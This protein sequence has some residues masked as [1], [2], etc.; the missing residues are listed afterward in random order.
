MQES[1]KPLVFLSYAVEDSVWVDAFRYL[2]RVLQLRPWMAPLDIAPGQEWDVMI[3]RAIQRADF[4]VA[5][6]SRTSIEKRGYV[7]REYRLALRTCNELPAE[8]SFLLPVRLDPCQVPDLEV[9]GR[10]LRDFQWVDAFAPGSF[11]RLL[12]ALRVSNSVHA[13]GLVATQ[14][15]SVTI[16]GV[17]DSL[18]NTKK[19]TYWPSKPSATEDFM[20]MPRTLSGT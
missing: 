2:L 18:S 11:V 9:E 7:Q 16:L 12:E 1:E 8:K 17:L 19:N 15:E 14:G 3:R 4:T 6:L 5:F 10:N 13:K 20:P